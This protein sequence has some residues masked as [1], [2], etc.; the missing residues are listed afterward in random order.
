MIP[1]YAYLCIESRAFSAIMIDN[2]DSFFLMKYP[3]VQNERIS[4]V[5]HNELV[6][7]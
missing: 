1:H 6:F 7:L 2:W 4:T 5:R 3:G